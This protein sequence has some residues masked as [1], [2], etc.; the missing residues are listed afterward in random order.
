[1]RRTFSLL[2]AQLACNS[3]SDELGACAAA[4]LLRL[5]GARRPRGAPVSQQLTEPGPAEARLPARDEVVTSALLDRWAASQPEATFAVFGDGSSWS[6]ERARAISC[7]SAARLKSLGV[8]SGDRVLSWQ[9][10][11][12]VAVATWFGAARLGA[13]FV[14]VNLAY[15]G[16]M[17]EHVVRL[18]DAAVAVVHDELLPELAGVT[19]TGLRHILRTGPRPAGGPSIATGDATG[20]FSAGG[21]AAPDRPVQPW[22]TQMIIYT[23]GTTGPSK[24]VLT[25][26]MQLWDTSIVIRDGLGPSD[27]YLVDLPMCHNGGVLPT[28]SMLVVGGSVVVTDSFKTGEFWEKIRRHRVTATNLLGV[29]ADFLAKQ[30]PSALDRD[31]GLRRVFSLPIMEDAGGFSDRFGVSVRTCYNMT[32]ISVPIISELDPRDYGPGY[33]G[34]PRP[35]VQVRVVDDNDL[36]VP[37][38]TVGELI[39]RT[40][41]PWSMLNGYVAM[42]QATAEAWRNGWF[43]TGDSFRRAADGRYYF[44]DR[45]KDAIRRR[46]ENISSF[47][48]EQEVLAHPAVRE[49]AAVAV[50][51][52]FTED[53]VLVAVAAGDDEHID[54]RALFDF[55]EPRMPYFMLPRYIRVLAELPRTETNKVRKQ[56]LREAGV[57]A[58]TWDREAAG[59]EVRKRTVR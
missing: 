57:T 16:R 3:V 27:R 11:G 55:L 24:G 35:G 43:H 14:P 23:S 44:V 28:Y 41:R 42:P 9:A 48:V 39:V 15:R 34:R 21:D 49:A 20:L 13:I 32:E 22:D 26:Y 10:N 52:E 18:A 56:E 12:P 59:I 31:H 58:G 2:N 46:G 6:Y 29:M 8:R 5:S 7:A 25:S 38:G 30:P 50:P 19:E 47:E 53:D 40:D 37:D 33:C 4:E 36:P 51:S 45:K 17:L 1:M 54:P